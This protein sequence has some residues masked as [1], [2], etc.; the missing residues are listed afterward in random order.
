M[1]K[2]VFSSLTKFE[3][4][5]FLLFFLFSFSLMAKTFNVDPDGNMEI[6][7][8]AWSDF[9]AT[10]PLIRSFSLG[11]NL[12]PE[13]PIYAGPPIRYHFMFFLAVGFLEKIGLPLDWA[14]NSLS[15]LGFWSLLILIYFTGKLI[16]KNSKV[17]ALAVI[18]F[19][20]N[21]SFGF[22]EFFNSHPV[23]TLSVGDIINNTSFT[24]F[25][26]YDGKIVSAF[27]NLNIY[28]NQRHLAGAYAAFLFLLLLMHKSNLNTEKLSVRK[29]IFIG[30]VLGFFPFIHFSVFLMAGVTL[31]IF[32]IIYP[33]LRKQIL[34]IGTLGLILAIPQYLYMGRSEINTELYNPGYLVNPLTFSN[35]LRY[36]FMNLGISVFLAPVGFFLANKEQRKILIPFISFFV[37]ANLFQFTPDMPT[38]HKFINLF[39]LGFNLFT[40]YFLVRTWEAK[41]VGR[42]IS[43]ALIVPL[44]LSGLLDLFPIYNDR[45]ITLQDIPHNK[46]ASFIKE[47][48]PRDSIFLNSSFLYH[49]ASIAGR[50]IFMGWP[51]FA[52][53]A[54]YDTN[55]RGKIME[56]IYTSKDKHEI[57]EALVK[58]NIDYFTTEDTSSNRDMPLIDLQFF[59]SNFKSLYKDLVQG[60]NIFDVHE[61]CNYS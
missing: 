20:F 35:F 17:G 22:I 11:D 28:T 40:S 61:N 8:K 9:A 13:Y 18:L 23:S 31:I 45:R 32:L 55:K 37:I 2:S 4:V 34:I 19:L 10:L 41:A 6:A 14:L 1:I 7:A 50:K 29:S 52:W 60:I 27:W 24:S 48:T 46:V 54:G 44:T 57:C 42:I 33:K 26:P 56:N 53:S 51:Y 43:T 39:M 38:N 25:G 36:W 16:F 30:T 47:S 58:N 59:E 3:W 12:P 21:G 15:T 49:P 5:L